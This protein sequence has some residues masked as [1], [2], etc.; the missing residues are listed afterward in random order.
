[1]RNLWLALIIGL[2]LFGCKEDKP[3]PDK[4][5]APR[6]YLKPKY[7]VPNQFTMKDGCIVRVTTWFGKDNGLIMYPNA[8][9][10]NSW[11]KECSE[12]KDMYPESEVIK[13]KYL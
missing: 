4:E 13:A 3:L 9:T 10:V 11:S 12:G 8:I 7:R 2:S 6:K 5:F 1:M